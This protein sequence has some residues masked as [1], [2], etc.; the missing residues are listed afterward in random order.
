MN[1]GISR[2]LGRGFSACRAGQRMGADCWG[3][4]AGCASGAG[5]GRGGYTVVV[6]APSGRTSG[7]GSRAGGEVRKL[8]RI[9]L[10]ERSANGV[11]ASFSKPVAITVT[12][13]SSFMLRS[14]TAPKMISASSPAASWMM[15]LIVVTSSIARS[16]PPVMLMSTP[17]A[18]WMEMLSSSG[19]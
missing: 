11:A 16:I 10:S 19:E 8:G 12:R 2:S 5:S 1:V 6:P 14:C 18:P 3:C 15:V 7:R 13:T 17:A 4:C 9:T